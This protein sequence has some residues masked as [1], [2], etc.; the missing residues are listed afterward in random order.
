MDIGTAYLDEGAITVTAV[1]RGGRPLKARTPL[2]F[3][4][5]FDR[6]NESYEAEGPFDIVLGAQTRPELEDNLEAELAM[7]WSEY[8]LVDSATLTPAAQRLRADLLAA[9]EETGNAA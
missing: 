7:L 3:I 6:E 4:V 9:F 5:T 8:A 1:S 2:K